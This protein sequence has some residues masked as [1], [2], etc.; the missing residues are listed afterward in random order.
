MQKK[1][2]VILDDGT[3]CGKISRGAAGLCHKHGG[4]KC[5]IEGC[6]KPARRAGRLC[7]EHCVDRA[8]AHDGA[9]AAHGQPPGAEGQGGAQRQLQES[10]G[11][12]GK[13]AAAKACL[14]GVAGL[15]AKELL[16]AG[17]RFL[18]SYKMDDFLKKAEM[19]RYL[20]DKVT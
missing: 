12:V 20:D 16:S 10:S 18:A 19:P 5:G 13:R 3:P 15:T 4:G 1:C 14:D 7:L 17:A 8:G 6:G 11:F 2:F 9:A